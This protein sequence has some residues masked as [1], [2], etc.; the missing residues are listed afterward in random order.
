MQPAHRE[1]QIGKSSTEFWKIMTRWG[2][3]STNFKS[4]DYECL[5]HGF[6]DIPIH[7]NYASMEK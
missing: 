1:L 7:L 2:T 6:H 5:L 4:G 3:V